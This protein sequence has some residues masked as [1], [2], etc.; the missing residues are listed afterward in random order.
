MAE[1]P[2]GFRKVAQ[3]GDVDDA[4]WN[5]VMEVALTVLT[6]ERGGELVVPEFRIKEARDRAQIR[7]PNGMHLHMESRG[8]DGVVTDIKLH[9]YDA[10]SCPH[11]GDERQIGTMPMPEGERVDWGNL[12]TVMQ[13]GGMISTGGVSKDPKDMTIGET[14]Q[15][16]HVYHLLLCVLLARYAPGG[17]LTINKDDYDE[18]TMGPGKF[19]RGALAISK[20]GETFSAALISDT[21]EG[22]D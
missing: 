15:V 7:Y 13:K 22:H 10:S 4:L 8:S 16:M 11:S 2:W 12:A 21:T 6:I 18:A 20:Q 5:H 3:G 14:R 9:T 1:D 19:G 17:T